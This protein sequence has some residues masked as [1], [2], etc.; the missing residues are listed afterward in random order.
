MN[1][2]LALIDLHENPKLGQ[3]TATHELASTTLMGRY[4]FVDVALTNLSLANIDN[5]AILARDNTRSIERHIG[6]DSTYLRNTKTGKLDILFNENGV[7]NGLFNTDVNNLLANDYVIYD[8][9]NKYILVVPVY[10]L[11]NIDYDKVIEEHKSSGKELSIVYSM[12]EASEFQGCSKL[13][14]D[15]IGNVQKFDKIE[16]TESGSVPVDLNTY[17]INASLLK[18]LLE[19]SKDI[20]ALSSIS[21]LVHYATKYLIVTHGIAYDGFVRCINSLK[22]YYDV[23]MELLDKLL[24]DEE[25]FADKFVLT[26]THNSR[27][28]IYG[29][30]AKATS[31][32]IANGSTINGE[33]KHSILA[34]DIVIEEGATVEDSIIFSHTIVRSGV[35]LKGVIADKRCV[36][37]EHK[38][39][40][41][42][43]PEPI[44]IPRGAKI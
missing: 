5:I 3:L 23:S 15:S 20:S 38:E 41:A 25:L 22:K 36:F 32:L 1:D 43:G 17:V 24:N 14:V 19:K 9:E 40:I 21:D 11:L 26:T 18:R 31:S 33:V 7:G 30:K 35:H 12:Q 13:A 28:V 44:Y 27:P 10:F 29:D 39:L 2:V 16:P 6:N 34:R 37:K 42:S 8:N 4:A